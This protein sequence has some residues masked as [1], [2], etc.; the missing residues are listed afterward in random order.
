MRRIAYKQFILNTAQYICVLYSTASAAHLIHHVRYS[1][2][3]LG[4]VLAAEEHQR[5][6]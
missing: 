3:R 5:L 2:K 4:L 1:I 6:L